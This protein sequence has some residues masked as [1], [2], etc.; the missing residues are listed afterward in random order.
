MLS[1]KRLGATDVTMQQALDCLDD[2]IFLPRNILF[3]Y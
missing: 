3:K 1:V 2:L